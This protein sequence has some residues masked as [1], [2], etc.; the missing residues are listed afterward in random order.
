M[1][2]IF[3][4]LRNNLRYYLR[5]RNCLDDFDR[6]FALLVSNKLKACLPSGALNYVLS[7]EGE[8]WYGPSKVA[9]LADTYVSNHSSA[10]KTK[11]VNSAFV[12]GG[13]G[14]WSLYGI[15]TATKNG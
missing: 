3:I 12:T 2:R 11:H 13:E 5:S 14:V 9:E 15:K 8:D 1:K 10:E 4:L 7:L 6:L